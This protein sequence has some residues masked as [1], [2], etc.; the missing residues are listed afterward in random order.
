MPIAS[1]RY[2]SRRPSTIRCS[3]AA[4]VIDRRAGL[5]ERDC[6]RLTDPGTRSNHKRDLAIHRKLRS[7]LIH[8]FQSLAQP[9]RRLVIA[10]T[11]C[12]DSKLVTTCDAAVIGL[13]AMGSFACCELA[14]RGM[15]VIGFDR[16]TPPHGRGSHSG[17]TRIFRIAYAEHPDYVVLALRSS[18]LW[19]EYAGLGGVP[20]LNRTGMLTI[21]P[22][23]SDLIR[24]ILHS[25]AIH[26]LQAVQFTPAEIR[27]AFPAFAP[28]EN[29]V[30]LWERKAGWI[31]SNAAIETAHRL[32]R[33][34]GAAL[35]L[36]E[37]VLQWTHEGNH[38]RVTRAS[39]VVTA[40]KLVITAGAWA[41]ELLPQLGLPL[42]I[43]RKVLTWVKPIDPA[44]FQPEVFPV[45]A[46]SEGFLYGFPAIG[47]HGVKL[48][49]HWKPGQLVPDPNE[50]V[51]EANLTDAA[52]PLALTAKLLPGLAGS[53]P[54]ALSRVTQMKTC[55]YVMS[56]DEHFFVDRHPEY[57]GLVFA[58]GFSGHGFKFA[59]AI[60][61]ILA[62]LATVGKA[63]LPIGFLSTDRRVSPVR[64]PI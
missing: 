62:D 8:G 28:D 41:G 55:L 36:D 2:G 5:C 58:A 12:Y 21:G 19:D 17:D 44:L 30:G 3:A 22:P 11:I 56:P 9:L 4:F 25:A 7:H 53:M 10:P 63:R 33:Q 48:S 6:C 31:D 45:F 57:P 20:L 32:A 16:F 24:G 60:G 1:L 34:S 47:D 18:E 51:P 35:L 27:C 50:P 37:P 59:P 14:R 49:V 38:F 61:E 42:R 64:F 29:H 15:R 26:E 39:G 52:E 23:E 46:F 54:D 40:E 43:V 13:G